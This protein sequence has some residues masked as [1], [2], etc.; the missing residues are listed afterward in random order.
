VAARHWMPGSFAVSSLAV[1]SSK[2]DSVMSSL[3]KMLMT[4]ILLPTLQA[5]VLDGE[6]WLMTGYC[7]PDHISF[8]CDVL[9]FVEIH[10]VCLVLC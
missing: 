1:I 8:L 2:K 7:T 9:F 4:G 10:L 5:T 6:D 3:D